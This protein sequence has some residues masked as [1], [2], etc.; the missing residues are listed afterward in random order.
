MKK[1]NKEIGA[2]SAPHV[3]MMEKRSSSQNY[4]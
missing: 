2:R 3:T 4:M 1:V